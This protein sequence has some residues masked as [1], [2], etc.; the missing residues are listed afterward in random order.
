MCLVIVLSFAVPLMIV[1]SIHIYYI[2]NVFYIV[3]LMIA[4]NNHVF[5]LIKPLSQF[6]SVH[7]CCLIKLLS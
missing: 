3:L 5:H 4:L 2:I 7:V 1:L 6:L